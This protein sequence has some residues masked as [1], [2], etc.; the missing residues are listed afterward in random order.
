MA[1]AERDATLFA[2]ISVALASARLIGRSDR[3]DFSFPWTG[4]G[5]VDFSRN[6]LSPMI[7]QRFRETFAPILVRFSSLNL[8]SDSSVINSSYVVYT[9]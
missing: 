1:A 5:A 7:T 6:I 3:N 2:A 8:R 9:L 4:L